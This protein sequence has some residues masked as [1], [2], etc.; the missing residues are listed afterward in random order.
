MNHTRSDSPRPDRRLG[1]LWGALGGGAL[2]FGLG[3]V[4]YLLITPLLD[5][6]TGLVRELQGFSWN[7]VPTLTVAGAVAGALL[8]G[9]LRQ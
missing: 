3:S 9:R 8:I 6:S 1:W 4:I 2:G 7:L 5:A